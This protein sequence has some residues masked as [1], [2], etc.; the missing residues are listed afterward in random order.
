M[1]IISASSTS[2]FKKT[3]AYPNPSEI[4]YSQNIDAK[5]SMFMAITD[6][7]IEETVVL[8]SLVYAS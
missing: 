1:L 8:L 2:P 4:K 6:K 5:R 7:M 3:S